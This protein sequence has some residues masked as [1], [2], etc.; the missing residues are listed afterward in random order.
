MRHVV[1]SVLFACTF[2][3][4]GGSDESGSSFLAV[5]SL[6]KTSVAISAGGRSQIANLIGAALCFLTLLWLTPLFHDMPHAG[7]ML[8]LGIAPRPTFTI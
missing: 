3:A 2:T 1:V 4:C 6:S 8:S 5:G 7:P